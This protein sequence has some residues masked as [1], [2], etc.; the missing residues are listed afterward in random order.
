MDFYDEIADAYDDI[1]GAPAREP[2]AREFVAAFLDRYRP[3]SALDAACGNGMYALALARAGLDVTG[4]DISPGMIENA[5]RHAAG[6][7]VRWVQAPM[8]LLADAVTGPFDAILC[9][10]N[11]IPHLL[12][13]ADLAAALNSF[14]RL[15]APGGVIV[16]NLLNYARLQASG[17][18]IVGIDR[19]GQH[20]Y[21]RFYDFLDTDRVRFNILAVDW[22]SAS[23]EPSHQLHS[24]TL[25]PYTCSA[26]RDALLAH[27]CRDVEFFSGLRFAPF[28]PNTSDTVTLV[29]RTA[30]F[31][32]AVP[33][34]S[35]SP[36]PSPSPS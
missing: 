24:T 23:G 31:S 4:A 11:S 26:L 27:G 28:D 30:R 34:L 18:R 20:E 17:E 36:S 3:G 10:G 35:P 2:A 15:A 32:D 12:T 33:S 9:M 29:A 5:R 8:Q 14:A 1:T 19:R 6:A 13:D 21:I 25:R 7:R 16:L 22:S